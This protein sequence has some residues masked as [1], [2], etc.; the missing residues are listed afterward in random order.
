MEIWKEECKKEKVKRKKHSW[1]GQPQFPGRLFVGQAQQNFARL[2]N[3]SMV[4]LG[5]F[6]PL[7]HQALLFGP[8][9][10]SAGGIGTRD[11]FYFLIFLNLKGGKFLKICT[12]S[13]LSSGMDHMIL[14]LNYA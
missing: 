10:G 3:A 5:D 11:I 8:L 1:L 6:I 12:F 7:A 2:G 13:G 4:S 9:L 14:I